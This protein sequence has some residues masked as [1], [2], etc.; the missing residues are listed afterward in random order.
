[1]DIAIKE[2][3]RRRNIQEK[4]NQEHGIIPKTIIKEI[5]E[6]I[7]NIEEIKDNK[8]KKMSNKEKQ[9]LINN[10]EREMKEAAKN[11]DFEKAMELRDALFELKGDSGV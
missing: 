2:T 7:S 11:L 4:Y 3:K 10:I 5:R 9:T 8:P 6:V 1:M